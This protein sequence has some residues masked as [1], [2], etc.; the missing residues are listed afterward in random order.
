[1][2]KIAISINPISHLFFGSRMELSPYQFVK[3]YYIPNIYTVGGV[4]L[5][6]VGSKIGYDKVEEMLLDNSITVKGPYLA[7]RFEGDIKFYV[8]A[9]RNFTREGFIRIDYLERDYIGFSRIDRLK[10]ARIYAEPDQHI[11]KPEELVF[12]ETEYA[13]GD[14]WRLNPN[15]YAK[16]K[17]EYSDRTSF[18][19][20]R[21]KRVVERPSL[22]HRSII[23]RYILN[24]NKYGITDSISFRCDLEIS[25]ELLNDIKDA[26]SELFR[27]GGEGGIARIEV[28]EE[29]TPVLN[30]N[31][32]AIEK[33]NI[34]DK[35][36][37]VSHIPIISEAINGSLIY[38]I[39]GIGY[40]DWIYGGVSLIGGWLVRRD[41]QK[42]K[43][44]ITAL[45]PGSVFKLKEINKD[46]PESFKEEWYFKLLFTIIRI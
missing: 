7:A 42:P 29:N 43:K 41:K 8:I 30:M 22:Y 13:G 15:S 17:I 20:D 36:L 35:Y 27:F 40:I 6:V 39:P 34:K 12:V 18:E 2:R 19:M 28:D 31:I 5:A 11:I 32:N 38:R 44:H 4:I 46:Y 14:V 23:E 25:D 37:A 9:P 10:T 21:S 45:I 24:S 26:T 16:L 1:M 3:S 33:L